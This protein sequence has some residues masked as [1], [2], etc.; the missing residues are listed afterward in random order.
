MAKIGIIITSF[1]RNEL[2]TKCL[3]SLNK[4]NLSNCEI[5]VVDQSKEYNGDWVSGCHY[6]KLP[7]NSG[8]SVCRNYGVQKAKELGCDYVIIGSD[9]FL[10]NESIQKINEIVDLLK[11]SDYS[12]CGFELTNC[13]CGWEAKLKLIEG[14]AFE[15]DFIDKNNT[16]ND[17][18]ALRSDTQSRCYEVD[19]CRN[20]FIAKIDM[21]LNVQ[22]DE[23]FRLLEHEDFFYRVKQT[24]YKGLWTNYIIAEKMTDRPHEY[25]E[26]R[27]KNMREG[28]IYLQKK[29]DITG[30]VKYIGL[31]KAKEYYAK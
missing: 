22:W 21:L 6:Y 29:W 28:R 19:I 18:W 5:I 23:N 4:F 10:F 8:L 30:W 7:F 9:S 16:N 15:L 14:Q 26:L 1:E 2:L 13:I 20:F 17:L 12:F 3:D 27:E 31:D 11:S 25:K 24:G